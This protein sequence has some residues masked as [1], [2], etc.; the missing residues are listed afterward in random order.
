MIGQANAGLQRRFSVIQK[1]T[2]EVALPSCI[3]TLPS[4]RRHMDG[5]LDADPNA[6][7]VS[8]FFVFPG[9]AWH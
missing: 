9:P 3:P 1:L 6:T 8:F 5:L 4:S 2:Q 7:V